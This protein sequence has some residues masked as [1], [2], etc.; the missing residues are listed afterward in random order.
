MRITFWFGAIIAR[1]VGASQRR[2]SALTAPAYWPRGFI[3]SFPACLQRLRRLAVLCWCFVVASGAAGRWRDGP[4]YWPPRYASVGKGKDDAA[5]APHE[6]DLDLCHCTTV[7]TTAIGPGAI[8]FLLALPPFAT[9][10]GGRSPKRYTVTPLISAVF[11]LASKAKKT[12]L[13]KISL[14]KFNFA[15]G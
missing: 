2:L 14:R 15:G 13:P 4:Y 12:L 11:K 1:S 8:S 9:C 5:V 10:S 6:V 3:S 7:P